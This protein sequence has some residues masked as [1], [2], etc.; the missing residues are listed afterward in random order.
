MSFCFPSLVPEVKPDVIQ[1]NSEE[2]VEMLQKGP[3]HYEDIEGTTQ[4]SSETV[5]L[6]PQTIQVKSASESEPDLSEVTQLT[7][8]L[9]EV[10]EMDNKTSS[11]KHVHISVESKDVPK[12]RTK[13]GCW[14]YVKDTNV[15]KMMK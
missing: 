13:P 5:M 3:S 8:K 14:D 1:A 9:V 12:V 4:H 7:S 6:N 15:Y 2:L 10:V 11:E